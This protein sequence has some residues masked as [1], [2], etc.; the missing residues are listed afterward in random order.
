[1]RKMEVTAILTVHMQSKS[2]KTNSQNNHIL[3]RA[4]RIL[5]RPNRILSHPNRILDRSILLKVMFSLRAPIVMGWVTAFIVFLENATHATERVHNHV[6][7]A[8]AW[9]AAVIVEAADITIM[10]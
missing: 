5:S 4:N 10:G 8:L 6:Q 9:A 2:L 3:S 7:P 1:M